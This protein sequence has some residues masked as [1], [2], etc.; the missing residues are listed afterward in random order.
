MKCTQAIFVRLVLMGQ[1]LYSPTLGIFSIIIVCGFVSCQNT[2]KYGFLCALFLVPQKA[3]YKMPFAER[4]RETG[5]RVYSLHYMLFP[6]ISPFEFSFVTFGK[7][8]NTVDV[9]FYTR[10]LSDILFI[11][12]VICD[13][14][15]DDNLLIIYLMILIS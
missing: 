4:Y 8:L 5:P 10:V 12:N 6:F 7:N 11:R 15:I 9:D 1:V 3:N 2:V 13:D 14:V